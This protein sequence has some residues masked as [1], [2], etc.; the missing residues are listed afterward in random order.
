MRQTN[1][2]STAACQGGFPFGKTLNRDHAAFSPAHWHAG[3]GT[4]WAGSASDGLGYRSG[5]RSCGV[6]RYSR[7]SAIASTTSAGGIWSG[8]GL[9]SHL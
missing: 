9:F 5:R 4:R 8:L 6:M 1:N 3:T 7:K 2:H